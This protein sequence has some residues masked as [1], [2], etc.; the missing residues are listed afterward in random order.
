MA[1][2]ATLSPHRAA[3]VLGAAL[4]ALA[5]APAVARAETNSIYTVAGTGADCTP[6]TGACGDGGLATLAQFAEP[7]D[8][9]ATSDGGYL[10]ADGS[11][12]RIRFVA[13]NGTIDTVAGDG[14]QC[15]PAGSQCGDGGLA[16]DAQLNNP[17]A[18]AALPDGGFLIADTVSD[19]IR[20]VTAGGQISTVAGNGTNCTS[21][22]CG[23]GG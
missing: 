6:V 21:G 2:A 11:A 10:V 1:Q 17:H 4:L 5:I 20:R 22:P 7:R 16:T 19:R 23:D 12:H 9:A 8:V 3:A 15:S 18:L 14:T 13:A